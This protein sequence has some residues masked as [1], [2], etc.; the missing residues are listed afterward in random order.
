MKDLMTPRWEVIAD[1]PSSE[2]PKGMIVDLSQD[3]RYVSGN[4]MGALWNDEKFFDSYPQLF[5]PL[6]W[7]EKRD[8]KDMPEYVKDN[9]KGNIV[10]K[11]HKYMEGILDRFFVSEANKHTEYLSHLAC[12]L[13][14]TQS[15][16]EAYINSKQLTNPQGGG[17]E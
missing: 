1:Y 9:F 15:E 13:P 8:I 16:Y 14:A 7:Y 11:V 17:G 6:A 3:P 10:I 4:V 2:Y 12:Y 5:K